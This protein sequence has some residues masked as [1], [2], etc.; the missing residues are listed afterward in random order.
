MSWKKPS[1]QEY[2]EYCEFQCKEMYYSIIVK[3]DILDH[4]I[5]T[6]PNHISVSQGNIIK[7]YILVSEIVP[8]V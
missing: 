8:H 2:Y 3:A 6:L 5:P 4:N 7:F 1:N